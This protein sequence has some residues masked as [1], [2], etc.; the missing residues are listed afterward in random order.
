MNDLSGFTSADTIYCAMVKGE[1]PMFAL[2]FGSG[3]NIVWSFAH[4]LPVKNQKVM[5]SSVG[6]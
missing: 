6:K 3:A 1:L 5:L 4:V 2:V